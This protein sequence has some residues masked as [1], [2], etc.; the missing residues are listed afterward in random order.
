MTL[1]LTED[2]IDALKEIANVGLGR[3][4]GLLNDMLSMHVEL[5]I[6]EVV[7]VPPEYLHE[8]LADYD[9]G[10]FS[11]VEL[12]FQG[13]Y[14]GVSSLLFPPKSAANLISAVTDEKVDAEN[15]SSLHIEIMH[16]LGSIVLNGI[17]GSFSNILGSNLRFSLP[18]YSENTLDVIEAKYK[19]RPEI[20]LI[21]IKTKFTVVQE[22]I[23]GHIML[24][25]EVASFNYLIKAIDELS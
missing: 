6:P 13:D 18:S 21:L 3:A 8:A 5:C 15:I 10:L 16:E 17:M 4:A 25:F 2:Q 23:E 22:N 24:F 7:G 19:E 9:E 1:D 14:G 20:I 11:I 12:P